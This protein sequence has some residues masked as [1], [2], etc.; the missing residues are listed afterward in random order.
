MKLKRSTVLLVGVALLMGAGVLIAESRSGNESQTAAVD[1]SGEPIFPFAET[2]VTQLRVERDGE[3]LAFTRD[4]SGN[5]QMAEPEVGPAEP[6]AV[7]YLL[8]RLNTDAPLQTVTMAPDA[9]ADF[10]LDT[11]AGTAVVTLE[12]GTEHRL[13]LGGEDFSGSARYAVIDPGTWPPPADAEDISVLVVSADVANGINRPL[14]EWKLPAEA[15]TGAEATLDNSAP[16]AAEESAAEAA[17]AEPS[18]P[19]EAAEDNGAVGA[20]DP[21]VVGEPAPESESPAEPTPEDPAPETEA[22]ATPE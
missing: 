17:P 6:A 7:A 15:T 12:D 16:E 3:T 18:E 21:P 22:E 11:P 13:M 9:L 4:D 19:G 8:S 20:P 2:A 1:S 14:E 5:W 10:G